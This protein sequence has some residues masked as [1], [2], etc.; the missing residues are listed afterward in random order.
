MLVSG[1]GVAGGRANNRLK[2][3][4]C[5]DCGAAALLVLCSCNV[6]V[7]EERDRERPIQANEDEP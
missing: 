2:G 5:S 6:T 1:G 4:A 3:G 7:S